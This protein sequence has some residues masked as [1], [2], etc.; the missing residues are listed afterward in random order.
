MDP[1]KWEAI[2]IFKP[3][4]MSRICSF[5]HNMPN[6]VH[7]WLLKFSGN[8]HTKVDDHLKK[9]Y[10]GLGLH[11]VNLQHQDVVMKLVF[12]SLVGGVKAWYNILP[13]KSINT[14][15]DIES[16]FLRKWGVE[17]DEAFLFSQLEKITKH[18]QEPVI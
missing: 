3:I 7:S 5:L 2:N 16:N 8:Y 13:S 10:D 9:F 4:D 15:E 18:E 1:P 17:K 11:G 6:S 14:W 12:D